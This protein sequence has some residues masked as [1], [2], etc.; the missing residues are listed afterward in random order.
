MGGGSIGSPASAPLPQPPRHL[1][2]GSMLRGLLEDHFHVK[3]DLCPK[4]VLAEALSV[5]G[6]GRA[7]QGEG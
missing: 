6:A 2:A 7:V 5:R 3:G 4:S 1:S